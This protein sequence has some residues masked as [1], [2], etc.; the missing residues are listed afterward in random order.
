MELNY[1]HATLLARTLHVSCNYISNIL[2]FFF[3]FF[4]PLILPSSI[5]IIPSPFS[6]AIKEISVLG[7]NFLLLEI[8]IECFSVDIGALID[9]NVAFILLG[10]DTL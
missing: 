2:I 5:E 4:F 9:V 1:R 10:I 8:G 3:S 7:F 6:F